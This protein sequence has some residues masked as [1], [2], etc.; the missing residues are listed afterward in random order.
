LSEASI[1]EVNCWLHSNLRFAISIGAMQNHKQW[2]VEKFEQLIARL[3]QSSEPSIILLG[4]REHT[5]A[6]ADLASR[7]PQH[8]LNLCG[9]TTVKDLAFLL[10][11]AHLCVTNDGGT[12]HLAASLG[13]PTVALM[14]GI[15]ARGSVEPYGWQTYAVRHSVNCAPCYSYLKCPKGHSNCM[16][17]IEVDQVLSKVESIYN[18]YCISKS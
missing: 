1:K 17:N 9:K 12:G 16:K 15:E 6:G 14:P 5:R 11:R 7:Y 13:T 4:T 18:E 8:V 10:K 2:P 3:I